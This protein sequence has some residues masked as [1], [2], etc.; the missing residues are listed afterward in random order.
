MRISHLQLLGNTG[1]P[2]IRQHIAVAPGV[3]FH[4]RNRKGHKELLCTG[5]ACSAG[6]S[7]RVCPSNRLRFT[8]K[9]CNHINVKLLPLSRANNI[10]I[11]LTQ[12]F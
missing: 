12:F 4:V 11:I 10:S 5:L 2:T 8:L 1:L 9:L 6:A 7:R 3:A